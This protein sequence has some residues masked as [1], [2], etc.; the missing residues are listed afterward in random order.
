M[1]DILTFRLAERAIRL[2]PASE[3]STEPFPP[4][5]GETE[6]R[7]YTAALFSRSPVIRVA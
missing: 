6:W 7:C 1:H 5:H 2:V 3:A 4:V